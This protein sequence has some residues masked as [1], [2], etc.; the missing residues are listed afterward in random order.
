MVPVAQ[1]QKLSIMI[2][3]GVLYNTSLQQLSTECG[4]SL[5]FKN[6]G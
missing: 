4:L 5:K 3:K 6:F 1:F 2:T